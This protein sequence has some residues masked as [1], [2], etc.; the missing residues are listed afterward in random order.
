MVDPCRDAKEALI[1]HPE[2]HQ[3]ANE[4]KGSA[5]GGAVAHYKFDAKAANKKKDMAQLNQI[6]MERSPQRYKTMYKD[7]FR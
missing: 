6:L 3:L 4:Y 5:M 2:K 1:W 7:Q